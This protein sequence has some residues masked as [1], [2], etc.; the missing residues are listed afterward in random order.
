MIATTQH[1]LGVFKNR[2]ASF[3]RKMMRMSGNNGH[4]PP[5][6]SRVAG[7]ENLGSENMYTMG[8]EVTAS[9]IQSGS[10]SRPV[11]TNENFR[12]A[13]GRP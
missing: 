7:R 3:R 8:D 11:F 2:L 12:P 9:R 1:S 4:A 10:Y 13:N 6:T 5:P